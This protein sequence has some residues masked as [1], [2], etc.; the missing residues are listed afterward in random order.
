MWCLIIWWHLNPEDKQ[1]G[2]PKRWHPTSTHGATT[3]KA[4][5]SI[6]VAVKIL[7]QAAG[8]NLNFVY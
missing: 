6:L 5:N 4:M 3:Q 8:P 2:P 7:I 1:H